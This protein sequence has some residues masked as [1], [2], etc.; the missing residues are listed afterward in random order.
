MMNNVLPYKILHKDYLRVS[1]PPPRV[2]LKPMGFEQDITR[3][4]HVQILDA[5]FLTH[6]IG[7]ITKIGDRDTSFRLFLGPNYINVEMTLALFYHL[8]YKTKPRKQ[9]LKNV[10]DIIDDNSLFSL[11]N[12]DIETAELAVQEELRKLEQNLQMRE[13]EFM[14]KRLRVRSLDQMKYIMPR[15][16]VLLLYMVYD[17]LLYVCSASFKIPITEP[18]SLI[19]IEINV[20]LPINDQPATFTDFMT[21]PLR[22]LSV[23]WRG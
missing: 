22:C 20:R 6:T 11:N 7:F 10:Y 13:L 14:S 5:K 1:P 2:S 9:F 12:A 15:H 18:R 8:V 4:K 23:S 19:K 17:I 21:L 16:K 3:Y